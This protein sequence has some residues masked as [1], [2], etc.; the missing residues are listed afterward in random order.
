M[1][2]LGVQELGDPYSAHVFAGVSAPAENAGPIGEDELREAAATLRKY[3]DGKARLESRIVENEKWYRLR[4]WDAIGREAAKDAPQPASAWL[5]NSLANKHADMMD[6][7]P[8]PNVL[9]REQGDE[10]DAKALS[11]I[12]PVALERND[13]EGVYSDACWY[14]LKNG[15]AAYGVFWDPALENGLGDIAI[16][17]LDLLNLFWE[18]GVRDL[19]DSR[20]LFV[21]SLVDVDL[22]KEAYPEQAAKLSGGQAL[23]VKQYVFDDT[24]DTSDKALVVDWYYKRRSVTGRKIV[25]LCKFCGDALLFASENDPEYQ[26]RGYYDHG[27]YPVVFDV[28]FPLEGMATGFGYVDVMRDPQLYIDRLDAEIMRNA[29]LVGRPRWFIKDDGGVN[30]AEFADFTKTFVHVAGRLDEDNLRQVEVTPLPAFISNHRQAKI[31]ELKETSGNRDFSQGGSS[32]GVTAASAIAALQEA[33][34]KLS[35]DMLKASYR[36]FTGI[37]NLCIELI[38]QFYDEA[39]CFRVLGE[40]GGQQYIE[41]SNQGIREQA[42]PPAYP[43][44]EPGAR[45]PVFDISVKPQRSNPFNRVSQNELAKELYA[46]GF[47]DPARAD[48]ALMA[49]DLMDF[50]G[51]SKVVQGIRRNKTLY[52]MVIEQRQTMDKMAAVIEQ[53]TGVPLA[54][55]GGGAPAVG[56]GSPA[57]MRQGATKSDAGQAE[58]RAAANAE[59]AYQQRVARGAPA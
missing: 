28:L 34:N 17:K 58:Q 40:D 48:M 19:Q 23:D 52:D 42:L 8:A 39:R 54:E 30:E 46:G 15:T 22:L 5:F 33:G 43:G 24:V 13:F 29:D 53:L 3:K 14:K 10:Q 59:G 12:L 2:Y 27:L 38:R 44:G 1:D 51:K 49:L 56:G 18:P 57:Q 41:Y 47:F 37:C 11:S 50:E 55:Q 6:N 7:F 20:N 16:R 25:H 45:R 4:H 9:P 21:V 32:G 35:R 31:D 26:E 36:S